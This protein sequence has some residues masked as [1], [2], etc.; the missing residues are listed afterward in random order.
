MYVKGVESY[1]DFQPL[2]H[3]LTYISVYRLKAV[4]HQDVPRS[5]TVQECGQR[6]G[7]VPGAPFGSATGSVGCGVACNGTRPDSQFPREIL[8]PLLIQIQS[9]PAMFL[10][11]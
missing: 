2:Q 7:R 10:N 8:D 6:G 1:F 5:T 9:N 11:I 3:A 4:V